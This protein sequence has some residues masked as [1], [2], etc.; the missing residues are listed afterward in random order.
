MPWKSASKI[1]LSKKQEQILMEYA[2]GTHTPLHLKKRSQIVL[3]AAKGLS[4]N[5]I[6][7]DMRIDPTTVK[8]WRDRYSTH[9]EELKRVELETPRNIRKVI[10]KV[11]SDE[12]RPGG[13]PTF[14]D[15]QVA[16]IIALACE[17]PAAI[18]L[19]FSHWTP[20]LLQQQAIKRGIVVSI[21]GRHISRFLKRTRLKAS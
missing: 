11:L 8:R 10:T 19:P 3:N 21:S 7:K 9:H 2:S 12:Q 16:A 6:E 4:N 1:E 5:D 17:D 15:E 20:G 14:S 18:G 13:P